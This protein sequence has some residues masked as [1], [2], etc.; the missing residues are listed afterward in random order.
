ME[1]D[2][3][4]LVQEQ[5][6]HWINGQILMCIYMLLLDKNYLEMKQETLIELIQEELMVH[7]Q[8]KLL[9]L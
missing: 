9:M 5:Q 4:D 2:G 3:S 8:K 7:I 6:I 1:K